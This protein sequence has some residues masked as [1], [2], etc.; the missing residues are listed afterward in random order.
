MYIEKPD[1][2]LIGTKKNF[3]YEVSVYKKMTKEVSKWIKT[4]DRYRQV[5]II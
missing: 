5:M 3:N 2:S 1:K 4:S